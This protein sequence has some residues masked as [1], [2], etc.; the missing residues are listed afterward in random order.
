MLRLLLTLFFQPGTCR[1]GYPYHGNPTAEGA[2]VSHPEILSEGFTSVNSPGCHPSLPP[3]HTHPSLPFQ[4]SLSARVQLLHC[5]DWRHVKNERNQ[6]YESADSLR[7]S[8]RHLPSPC[9]TLRRIYCHICYLSFQ[10]RIVRCTLSKA[11]RKSRWTM[12][13]AP[14]LPNL[15]FTPSQCLT[16]LFKWNLSI[17]LRF[18]FAS[19]TLRSDNW[20]HFCFW[21]WASSSMSA[22]CLDH[23]TLY[24]YLSCPG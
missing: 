13:W 21:Y 18:T 10:E 8:D 12:L 15:Y 6:R 16:I 20:R 24:D 4:H 22:P 23:S 3:T 11:F 9:C 17:F 7:E 5:W 19:L 14:I 2:D 1:S